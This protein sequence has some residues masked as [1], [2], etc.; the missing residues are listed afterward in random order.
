[1]KKTVTLNDVVESVGTFSRLLILGET[2]QLD[3]NWKEDDLLK[4]AKIWENTQRIRDSVIPLERQ[5]SILE[6]RVGDINT[7]KEG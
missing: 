6:R 4:W 7:L 2:R 5:I 1:M 3:I